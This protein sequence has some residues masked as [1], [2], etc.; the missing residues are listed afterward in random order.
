MKGR[1]PLLTASLLGKETVETHVP[2]NRPSVDAVPAAT[3]R[4]AVYCDECTVPWE[5]FCAKPIKALVQLVPL[6]QL[7]RSTA[8]ECKGWHDTAK[9]GVHDVIMDIWRRQFSKMGFQQSAPHQAA[10][11]TVHESACHIGSGVAAVLG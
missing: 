5:E 3:M 8:C 9:L 6:L 2:E 4:V 10:I 1:T 11:Y 7:C